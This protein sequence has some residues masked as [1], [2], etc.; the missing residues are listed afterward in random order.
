MSPSEQSKTRWEALDRKIYNEIVERKVSPDSISEILKKYTKLILRSR[1]KSRDLI[2]L[3]PV[4]DGL[5]KRIND[6][7]LISVAQWLHSLNRLF[8][9]AEAISK[10]LSDL[11]LSNEIVMEE[12]KKREKE[13]ACFSLMA[14]FIK[15]RD[16]FSAGETLGKL[17]TLR[18]SLK[19]KKDVFGGRKLENEILKMPLV[20]EMMNQ[21]VLKIDRASNPKH[22]GVCPGSRDTM[23]KIKDDSYRLAAEIVQSHFRLYRPPTFQ[24]V[25]ARVW[26]YQLSQGSSK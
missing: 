23:K 15:T 7:D 22:G 14:P 4:L 13:R 18:K 16:L 24:Q 25:R 3:R 20:T 6:E 17:I 21:L 8:G 9:G 2:K 26:K 10:D 5:P 12:I 19:K 11:T 1:F